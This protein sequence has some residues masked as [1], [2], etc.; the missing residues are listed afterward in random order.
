MSLLFGPIMQTCWVVR[1]LE[2]AMQHWLALGV[3]PFHVLD[4]IAFEEITHRG[5]HSPID[6]RVGYA[7][8]GDYQV[9]LVQQK[10]AAP[11]I[12]HE[13]LEAGLQG[14]HHVGMVT[15]T[16]DQHLATADRHGFDVLQYGKVEGGGRIAYLDTQGAFPGTIIEIIEENEMLAGAFAL[17]REASANWDG[18]TDPVRYL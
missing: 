17:F 8:S 14:Q 5:R 11:S 18:K 3:G 12:Y 10:N 1:D 7:Y 4:N 6:I 13:F 2:A 9:E 16:F 15:K